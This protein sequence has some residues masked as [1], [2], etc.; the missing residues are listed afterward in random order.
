VCLIGW[1]WRPDAAERL[2]LIANRDEFYDRPALPLHWWDDAPILAG[3]DLT[4]GGTWLGVTRSGRLAALTN[5]RLP[6]GPR[7]GTKSRGKVVSEFLAGA[8]PAQAYLDGLRNGVSD[9]NPFNLLLFDGQDL[10]GFESRHSRVVPIAPGLSGVSNAD[11]FTPW[12]KLSAVTRSMADLERAGRL[13]DDAGLMQILQD[14]NVAPDDQLPATGIPLE[15]ERQLSPAF[16]RAPGYGT[17]A[18]TIVR[19]STYGA[20]VS[21]RTYTNGQASGGTQITF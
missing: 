13:A 14:Q 4:G 21:E 7:P 19:M 1:N 15:R 11:F 6:A 12:P 20:S 17:R 5:Y 10:L 9:F 18:S 8:M 16:I 3:R 2:L